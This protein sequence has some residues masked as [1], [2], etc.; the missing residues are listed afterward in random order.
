MNKQDIDI[1]VIMEEGAYL[2]EPKM[3]SLKLS[4]TQIPMLNNPVGYPMK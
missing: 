3:H 1:F 2:Y 4:E